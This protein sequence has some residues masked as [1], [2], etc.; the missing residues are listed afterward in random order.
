MFKDITDEQLLK[1][2]QEFI[3]KN[4]KRLQSIARKTKGDLAFEEMAGE[5]WLLIRNQ[6]DRLEKMAKAHPEMDIHTQLRIIL[7]ADWVNE[8]QTKSIKRY[9]KASLD[10]PLKSDSYDEAE[11]PRTLA[12]IIRA[13][14]DIEP[15]QILL[16][17][18]QSQINERAI[19]GS[20]SEACAYI[21]L[22]RRFLS[23]EKII[24]QL[25]T[26]RRNLRQ[27]MAQ[28]FWVLE[29]QR[30]LFDGFSH[31]SPR[32]PFT[33]SRR[34]SQSNICQSN[35]INKITMKEENQRQTMLF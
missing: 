25:K 16:S 32:F 5:I 31:I 22:F 8:R 34:R 7:Y 21:L 20:Y 2:I 4:R 6:L 27:K 9:Q 15:L 3:Q 11:H 1:F 29:H 10:A 23:E 28:A 33:V 19:K 17:R 18:E 35:K 30:M 12:D 24:A 14:E 13:S 26:S